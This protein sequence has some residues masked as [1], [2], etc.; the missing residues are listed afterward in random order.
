MYFDF[1]IVGFSNFPSLQVPF[2]FFFLLSHMVTLVANLFLIA[3]IALGNLLV[4]PMYFFLCNL[5]FL[6]ITYTSVTSPKLLCIFIT[7][8]GVIS[9]WECILQYTLFVAFTSVEYFLLTIMSYDRYVAVCRPLHYH[10]VLNRR[11]CHVASSTIW[12]CGFIF[13]LPIS[14]TTSRNVYCS[15]NVINHYFCDI[16]VLLELSCSSTTLTQNIILFEGALFFTSCFLPTIISYVFIMN[17]VSK[18]NILG[19]KRKTFSTCAS[20]LTTVILFYS[21]IF[22]LYIVPRASVTQN[23][24]KVISVLYSNVIPMLNPLVYSLR[25]KDVWRAWKTVL[26]QKLLVSQF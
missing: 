11:F 1:I 3:L 15:S 19:G 7:S 14:I 22:T 26:N 4:N 8:S 13:C 18:I 23:Q 12:L 16:S 20:H 6:D 5:A 24:R 21:V 10:M 9:H 25:N 2:V 17:T